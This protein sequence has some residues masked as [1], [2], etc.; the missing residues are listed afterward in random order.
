M[1]A[2]E[3]LELV[4]GFW[5]EVVLNSESWMLS[6]VLVGFRFMELVYSLLDDF[7]NW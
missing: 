7:H 3:N 1:V 4:F 6:F 2:V 5:L